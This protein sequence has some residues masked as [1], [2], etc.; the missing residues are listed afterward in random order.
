MRW[1]LSV[2]L[3]QKN[4]FTFKC[5]VTYY[6]TTKCFICI[7]NLRDWYFQMEMEITVEEIPLF[8][9]AQKYIKTKQP[10]T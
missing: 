7:N 6:C 9:Q 4:E 2:S 1:T 5:V 3:I 8:L 10:D